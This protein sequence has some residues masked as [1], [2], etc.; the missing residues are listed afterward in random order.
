MTPKISIIIP[1][2]NAERYLEQ[3]LNSVRQQTLRDIEIICVDD[4]SRDTSQSI[5]KKVA[6][7]DSR[8][9]LCFHSQNKSVF[10]ARKTGVAEATGEYIM[11]LD[12]DDFL[13]LLACEVLYNKIIEAKVD[14]LHFSSRVFFED[15]ENKVQRRDIQRLI[16]PYVRELCGDEVF[17]LGFAAQNVSGTLWNK[18]YKTSVCKKTFDN[19]E[20]NYFSV[21]EDVF[22]FC[23]IALEAQS[24]LGWNSKPL[25]NYRI[26]NGISTGSTLNIDKFQRQC[27]MAEIHRKMSDF[28]QQKGVLKD[29]EDILIQLKDTWL[30]HCCISWYE[31]LPKDY[32]AEGWKILCAYWGAEAVVTQL[33]KNYFDEGTQIAQRLE[34][35]VKLPLAGRKIKTVGIYYHKLCAGGV[36]RV[37]SVLSAMLVKMGYQVVVITDEPP[38][39]QDYPIPK[40]AIRERLLPDTETFPNTVGRRFCTWKQ[41]A[42]KHG[43]DVILYN[44]WMSELLLWDMLY[45]KAMDIP[46]VVHAHGVFG[47]LAAELK[48][49]L[50]QMPRVMRLSDGIITLSETDKWFWDIYSDNVHFIPNPP[51]EELRCARPGT[52]NSKSLIWVGRASPEKQPEKIFDIMEQVIGQIPDAKLLVL[53][54]FDDPKWKKLVKRKKLEQNVVFCGMVSNVSA[55]LEQASVFVCTSQFEG[56]PMSLVEAQAHALPTVM[57][58]LPHVVM[59]STDRGV[60]SVDMNDVVSAAN[61]IVKLLRDETHWRTNSGMAYRSY[62]WLR[63]YDLQGAWEDLLSGVI[64]ESSWE[65]KTTQIINTLIAHYD[66]GCQNRENVNAVSWG[67]QKIAGGIQCGI[68]NGWGYTFRLALRRI[69]QRFIK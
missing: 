28:C 50:A 64:A 16:R 3:C 20:V 63:D 13:E 26:G 30:N 17:R 52:W 60:I 36:E 58:R 31:K 15:K 35:A 14:I 42:E 53:G 5:L 68:E 49:L 32:A 10:A 56:F 33:A 4:C 21:G 62:E 61:E 2:Y 67:I 18:I 59:A 7:D 46:V 8:V 24:Y 1:V 54:N 9:K 38:S 27:T 22:T 48:N 25:Y 65:E 69:R 44:A 66:L 37:I 29:A 43:V 51:A 40:V 6:R 39:P 47:C 41:V 45:L 19:L 12:S 55:Y 34:D 23:A 57:F 11:F